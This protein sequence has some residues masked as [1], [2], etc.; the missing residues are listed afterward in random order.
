[1]R[2]AAVL[3]PLLALAACGGEEPA[4]EGQSVVAR[5]AEGALPGW[6]VPTDGTDPARW[7]AG[8]E[9]GKPLPDD[10]PEVAALRASLSAARTGFVEDPRM[11]ANRTV[12]LGQMLT[13]I[14]RPESYRSLIDGLG[15]V[16][17]RRG[18]HKSLYGEMVQHYY[19]ARAQGADHDGALARLAAR[20]AP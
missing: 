5:T 3:L 4:E 14:G 17:A 8:R 11:I 20:E 13:E 12:Q 1:M 6:L 7:L 19:N 15:G 9:A 16:A 2:R 18:R 10:A